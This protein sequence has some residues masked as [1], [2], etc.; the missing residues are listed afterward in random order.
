MKVRARLAKPV[1]YIDG[2]EPVLV[3]FCCPWSPVM[4]TGGLVPAFS[5]SVCQ[6]RHSMDMKFL[7][8]DTK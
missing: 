4:P 2:A 1:N 3:A 5:T 6:T 8:I 7:N